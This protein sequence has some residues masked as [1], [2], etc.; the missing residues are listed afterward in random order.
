MKLKEC[1]EIG[2]ACELYSIEECYDNIILHNLCLFKCD[3]I[4]KEI[5]ELQKDIFHNYPKLFS[6]MFQRRKRII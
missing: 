2:K 5:E 4:F 1:M 3:D 6:E